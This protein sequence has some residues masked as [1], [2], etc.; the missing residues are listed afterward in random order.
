MPD[1]DIMDKRDISLYYQ[2]VATYMKNLK[3]HF[4]DIIDEQ[5]ALS[6]AERKLTPLEKFVKHDKDEIK[7]NLKI[8]REE[9][10][11]TAHVFTADA[12]LYSTKKNYGATAH[13]ESLYEAIDELKAE[14]QKKMTRFKGKRISLLKRGGR[15]AK[16][17]LRRED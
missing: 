10:S 17:L 11:K 16:R 12:N 14:L 6:Y 5:D 9:S 15:E 1:Y 7:W 2:L 4:Q 13:G 3:V 8:S